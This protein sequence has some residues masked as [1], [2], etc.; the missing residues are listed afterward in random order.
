M[1]ADAPKV[2]MPTTLPA[3]PTQRAQPKVEA[4]LIFGYTRA[5]LPEG[6]TSSL[7]PV[8]RLLFEQVPRRHADHAGFHAFFGE[9]AI[10]A[11]TQRETSLPVPIRITSGL[12]SVA[13]TRT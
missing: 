13:S 11:L 12:P 2:V 1:G 6:S 7:Y 10:D 9:V 8:L 3:R 5:D 4:V